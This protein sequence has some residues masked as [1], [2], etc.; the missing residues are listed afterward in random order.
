[1]TDHRADEVQEALR[2]AV[3]WVLS[4]RLPDG[5]FPFVPGRGF[6]YGHPELASGVGRGAMFPT[7][8]RTLALALAAQGLPEDPIGRHPWEFVNCPGYQSWEVMNA[9]T[10]N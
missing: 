10:G 6:E 3:A 1:L 2:C 5:G 8:F 4:T 9:D 7:W